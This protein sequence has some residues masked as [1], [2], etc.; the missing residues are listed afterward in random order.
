[1]ITEH[2]SN[3]PQMKQG[4]KPVVSV[5]MITYN[6]RE[7]IGE[8]LESAVKQMTDFDYEILVGDDASCD[9]TQNIILDFQ[10]RYPDKI[11]ALLN[12]VNLGCL[13]KKNLLN[14]LLACRG[15]YIALLEGDDYWTSPHKLQLQ[16]DFL[17]NCPECVMCF[18][19]VSQVDA[20]R[21]LLGQILDSPEVKT[22]STLEDLIENN[23]IGTC[24]V[25]FRA[26]RII[27]MPDWYFVPRLGDWTLHVLLA[28][29]G[30]IGRVPGI[31]A[32]HRCHPGGLW[33]GMKPKE[34]KL[35]LIEFYT[36]INAHLN[37]EFDRQIKEIVSADLFWLAIIYA[38][39]RRW[40]EAFKAFARS[41]LLCPR[42]RR[43]PW[44]KVL[45]HRFH[46]VL[47]KA[48]QFLFIPQ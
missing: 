43:I 41:I 9:G 7:F 34:E 36:I 24:S 3:C 13:G 15:E 28:Q 18:H 10:N 27:K 21:N 33:T 46:R 16:V 32:A 6:H 22:I 30:S 11:R 40:G 25:M 12:P 17:R 26:D 29:S 4:P 8:A 2:L 37:F 35:A 45:R 38:S 44:G 23:F 5:L 1:L 14:T 42:N 39:E 47:A 31:M 48:R 19:P 20:Q